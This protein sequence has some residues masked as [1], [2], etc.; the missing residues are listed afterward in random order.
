MIDSYQNEIKWAKSNT[1][2][3]K[4]LEKKLSK[5]GRSDLLINKLHEEVFED[6]DCLKCANCCK[7]TGPLL[8]PKDIQR[9]SKRLKMP[10]KQFVDTFLRVDEDGDHVFQSM[11][12]P[13]LEDDNKCAVYE[14][15]PKA[16]RAY[17][18]TDQKG[19]LDIFAI[20]R[21]N[22]RICPAVSRIMQ[23]LVSM[24]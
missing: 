10:E 4:S 7:T 14:D 13:F 21:K 3:V 11:P 23:I 20:T 17:P 22:A 8:L 24:G 12:C 1:K 19:Q 2:K 9:L 15:R 18:H 6:V 16:C 5:T